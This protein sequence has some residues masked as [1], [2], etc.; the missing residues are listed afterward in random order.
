MT[1]RK[2]M[3]ARG[4][5]ILAQIRRMGPLMEGSLTLTRKKC[6]HPDCRCAEEG[7]ITHTLYVLRAG[8]GSGGG[9]A[10]GQRGK[11]D[12]AADQG[13]ERRA[14]GVVEEEESPAALMAALCKTVPSPRS[15]AHRPLHAPAPGATPSHNLPNPLL[16]LLTLNLSFPAASPLPDHMLA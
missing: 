7:R 10:M 2:A 13:S 11:A 5:A 4:R 3:T 8:G 1:R 16:L 14:A 9:G 12:Q 15:L 6:G